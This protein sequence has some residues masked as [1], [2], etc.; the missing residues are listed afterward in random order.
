MIVQMS[1]VLKRNVSDS[2][3]PPTWVYMGIYDLFRTHQSVYM[4]IT[5]W[6]GT[7][8]PNIVDLATN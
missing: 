5:T 7:L 1:V 8:K 2:V 3:C 4:S 6:Y